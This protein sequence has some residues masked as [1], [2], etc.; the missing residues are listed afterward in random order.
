VLE[1]FGLIV[2]QYWRHTSGQGNFTMMGTEVASALGMQ[3]AAGND[4]LGHEVMG[5]FASDLLSGVTSGAKGENTWVTSK[6]TSGSPE[7]MRTA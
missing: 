2:G 7:A 6:R 3:V 5:G 4:D 1:I